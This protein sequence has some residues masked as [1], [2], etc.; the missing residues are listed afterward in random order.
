[1]Q[2]ELYLKCLVSVAGWIW[3]NCVMSFYRRYN[4][5]DSSDDND[6]ESCEYTVCF[7]NTLFHWIFPDT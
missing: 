5:S 1:M 2:F 7:T 6:F 3:V 4:F